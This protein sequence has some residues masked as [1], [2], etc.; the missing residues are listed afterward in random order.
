MAS[1]SPSPSS[2]REPS[3][4]SGTDSDAARSTPAHSRGTTEDRPRVRRLGTVLLAVEALAL[5]ALGIFMLSRMGAS[6]VGASFAAGLGAFIL[7]FALGV[8]VAAR[9][10]ARRGRFG[11]GFGV[12]WQLFQALVAASMLRAGVVLVGSIGL[13]LAIAAFVVLLNLVRATPLPFEDPQGA[14]GN[15]PGPRGGRR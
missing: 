14:T 1:S 7:L 10:L 15:G 9:S 8:G 13:L 11:L 12:T 2:P 4:Q 6:D 3:S 5:L